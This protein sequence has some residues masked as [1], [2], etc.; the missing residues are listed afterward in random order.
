ME[1]GGAQL[2]DET[3]HLHVAVLEFKA[4]VCWHGGYRRK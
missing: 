3:D 2:V 1:R 4:L